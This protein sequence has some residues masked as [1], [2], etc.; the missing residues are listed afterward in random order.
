M[1]QRLSRT[2]E[3]VNK[4]GLH[5]RASSKFAMLAGEYA[6]CFIRVSREDQE[7][8]GESIMDLMM[9]AAGIGSE[10]VVSAEGPRAEA[11]LDALTDLVASRFGED[12]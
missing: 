4:R 6:D 11:A 8:D 2:F 7:V 3:I 12:E 10:I 9:L 1:T 5:A